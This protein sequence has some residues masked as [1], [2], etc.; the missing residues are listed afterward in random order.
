MQAT[1]EGDGLTTM[2]PHEIIADFIWNK[3]DAIDLDDMGSDAGSQVV[4]ALED[5]GWRIIP[6]GQRCPWG[7]GMPR[8]N[9]EPTMRCPVCGDLG[10]DEA[11]SEPSKCIE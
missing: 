10:T 9:I 11:L 5:G 8:P 7:K 4:K 1:G 6:I 3:L 2:K